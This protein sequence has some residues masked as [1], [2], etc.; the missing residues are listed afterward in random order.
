MSAK[1]NDDFLILLCDVARHFNTYGDRLAQ[2]HGV[3][4]TQLLLLA[5]LEMEPDL[6]QCELA[7]ICEVSAMTIAR[8]V[9]RLE[10]LGLVERRTDPKDRRIWRLRLTR[11]AEPLLGD[12][13]QIRAKLRSVT[14]KGI[15]PAVLKAMTQGLRQMKENVRRGRSAKV[16]A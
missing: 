8:V 2:T 12:I 9:D 16:D 11:K 4:H 7:D 5:R 15:E 13:R 10:A 6:S 1:L 14:T 3:T